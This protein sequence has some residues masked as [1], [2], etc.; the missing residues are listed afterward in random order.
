MVLV[1]GSRFKPS[2]DEGRDAR[3]PVVSSLTSRAAKA[4]GLFLKDNPQELLRAAKGAVGFRLGVPLAALR[5]LL[6]ELGGKKA[7][8]DVVLRAEARGIYVE[9]SVELMQT[10]LR[11]STTVL[12]DRIET[13][14]HS[15]LLDVRLKN[16]KLRVLDE[17]VGT[18]VAALLQSGAL[19]TSRPGDLLSYIPKKP[20]FIIEAK[21]DAFRL[22]LMRLPSLSQD[23]ARRILGA[24][25]PLVGIRSVE[26]ADDH[27]D[28]AL[29]P[30][31]LGPSAAL[32]ALK[33]RALKKLF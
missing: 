33:K 13:G 8:K 14:A 7:P 24:L 9:A 26:T 25:A 19:D 21:G 3:V 27:L 29:N 31:P 5:W 23:N 18:P 10:P 6:R 16:L 30:L 22:D 15:L 11:V 28:I 2:L 1:G 32:S 12:V 17:K 20:E 4:A